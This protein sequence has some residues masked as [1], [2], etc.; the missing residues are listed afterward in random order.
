MRGDVIE[1]VEVQPL[2]RGKAGHERGR[3]QPLDGVVRGYNGVGGTVPVN[4]VVLLVLFT[5]RESG[6]DK[7]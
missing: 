4:G 6:G 2:G 7:V 1:A 3:P 5:G